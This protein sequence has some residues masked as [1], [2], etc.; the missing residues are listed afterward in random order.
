MTRKL[1]IAVCAASLWAGCRGRSG[2]AR[3]L[4][5]S[6]TVEL[7]APGPPV[8]AALAARLSSIGAQSFFLPAVAGSAEGE[9]V[10]FAAVERSDPASLP[11]VVYLEVGGTGDFDPPLRRDSKRVASA[12]WEALGPAVRHPSPRVAGVHLAWRVRDSTEGYASILDFVRRRLPPNWTLSVS[13]DTRIP[14]SGRNRWKSVAQKTDFLV[15]NLFG[16]RPDVRPEGL[17]FQASLEDLADLEVPVYAGFAPQG[18]G[19]VR[20]PDGAPGPFIPD[21]AVNELSKDRRFDFSFGDVLTDPDEDVYVFTAKQEARLPRERTVP[22]GSTVTFR[23]ARVS[24]L[25]R[26]LAD[27]KAA[28]GKVIRFA[29]LS[30]G[31]HL[32]GMKTL[33]EVLFGRDLRPRLAFS[34]GSVD[35][36]LALVAVNPNAEWSALSRI[37]NWVDLRIEGARVFDLRPG[38]FD[39]F[40]FLDEKGRP[41][42]AA[43]ARTIRLFENFVAPGES[44]ATGPIRV[45]GRPAMSASAHL[46]LPDG[47]TLVVPDSRI[48]VPAETAVSAG[49]KNAN[50]VERGARRERQAV[51]RKPHR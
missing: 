4:P 7:G 17:R 39:R 8:D 38:E 51:E 27:A 21:G 20:M 46:T 10:A 44:I 40:V 9:S 42:T 23:E 18:W 14:E 12:L 13:V 37:N 22:A 26:S 45:S 33:E 15:A 41:V 16:R 31:S 19:V 11:G 36:G 43:R 48:D 24:D 35:G 47:K 29:S 50:R 30:D 2:P 49:E 25:L 28:P 5:A 6:I 32:F 34:V 3:R 1:L